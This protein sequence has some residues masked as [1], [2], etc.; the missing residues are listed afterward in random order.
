MNIHKYVITMPWSDERMRH[1]RNEMR[2]RNRNDVE[3]VLGV[4]WEKYVKEY[5]IKIKPWVKNLHIGNYLS[6][7]RVLED[8]IVKWYDAIIIMEDDL[9]LGNFFWFIYHEFLK[10]APHDRGMLRL[11][12]M[13]KPNQ[14]RIS[15]SSINWLVDNGAYWQELYMLRWDAIKKVH[16]YLVS[17][18]LEVPID[19]VIHQAPVKAYMS[20]QPMWMQRDNYPLSST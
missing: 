20:A 12:W 18:P 15:T 2:R 17:L 19:W 9:V 10:T 3:E 6:H 14:E 8:A 5:D 11:S 13:P 7:V 1:F 4:D 16:D